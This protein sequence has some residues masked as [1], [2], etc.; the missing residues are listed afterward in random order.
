MRWT[1]GIPQKL[2]TASLLLGIMALVVLF[3]LIERSNVA[4]LN[5]SV[6]S[7]YKDRLIPATDIF[8]MTEHLYEKRF[9]ME[10]FLAEDSNG[11]S[12]VKA[13]LASHNRALDTL[14][15][16]FEQTYLIGSESAFLASFRNKARRYAE[17][18][19]QTLSMIE[20]NRK[21]EGRA[22]YKTNG[23]ASLKDTIQ[24][25]AELTKVQTTVG[26]QLLDNSRGVLAVSKLV[27]SLQIVL[28]LI[29]GFMI[30]SLISASKIMRPRGQS[31]HLN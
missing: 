27:S 22:F 4:Q 17:V 19:Q 20:N 24:Q 1:Y 2:K 31:A 11:T 23:N 9:A 5:Q 6:N 15:Q 8:Y 16:K 7:I 21:I 28:T 30:N 14:V 10:N 25:L 26:G 13:K 18:E 29:I 3:N 12:N